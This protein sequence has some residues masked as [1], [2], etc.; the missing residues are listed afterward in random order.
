MSLSTP[1]SASPCLER[2]SRLFKGRSS[3]MNLTV[4]MLFLCLEESTFPR[5]ERI[6]WIE[7]GGSRI[8][9]IDIQDKKA[10]PI[11]HDRTFLD[12]RFASG[13]IHQLKIDPYQHLPQ[14]DEAF[15]HEHWVQRD[16]AYDLIKDIVKHHAPEL[17]FSSVLVPLLLN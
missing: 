5:I 9:T 13:A 16:Q 4:N 14:P 8:A 15:K 1:I 10:W 11:L 17:L 12:E 3:R 2:I 6:L 7:H